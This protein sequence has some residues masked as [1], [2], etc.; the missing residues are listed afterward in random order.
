MTK[1]IIEFHDDIKSQ[2]MIVIESIKDTIDINDPSAVLKYGIKPMEGISKFSD[3]LLVDI[4]DNENKNITSQLELLVSNIKQYIPAK[5]A[6][7]PK[8][9][10]MQSIIHKLFCNMPPVLD[11][12]DKFQLLATNVD[13]IASH[14]DH[15]MI[16]LLRD[17]EKMEVLYQKNFDFFR[18][19]DHY[20]RAGKE[21]IK[22]IRENELVK[23]QHEAD[24]TKSLL[25][26]QQTKDLIDNIN[27]FERRLQ[28]LEISKTISMQ[29][30]PQIRIIQNNNQQ[31][32]EKIQGS[33]LTTL[34]IWK[35]QV[36]LSKSLDAQ[37]KA[38]TLQKEVSDTT[39]EL[40]RYNA[41][42]LQQNTIEVAKEAERSI[43]DI[44]TIREVQ[45]KLVNTIEETM[46]IANDARVKRASVE[47][48]L[49]TMEDNLRL[50]ISDVVTKNSVDINTS[51]PP[52]RPKPPLPE[53]TRR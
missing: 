5:M 44:E 40:L 30:A 35:S 13:E 19:V 23:L 10:F 3:S 46:K 52:E 48:E 33:I 25:V 20:V 15:S 47:K 39:N 2:D 31:L 32:A 34:P 22:E 6:D 9:G 42:M 21:K 1:E 53:I 17:N 45:D 36:V 43:V 50:R 11:Q 12:D 16:G 49:E 38:V 8:M 29:T 4:K 24:T 26:A 18:E 37:K 14:L 27:R 28:D 41:G 51:T 7:I